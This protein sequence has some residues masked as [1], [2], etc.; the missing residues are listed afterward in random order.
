M[1]FISCY[2]IDVL[3]ILPLLD[4]QLNLVRRRCVL[5][6]KIITE[7]LLSEHNL[8]QHLT[9]LRKI[10]L[11]E[12]GNVVQNFYSYLF[13]EVSSLWFVWLVFVV[14]N[15]CTFSYCWS[16]DKITLQKESRVFCS[17]K[18]CS[19]VGQKTNSSEAL[20][21]FVISKCRVIIP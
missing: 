7:S 20:A 16:K 13:Q 14:V 10:F 3:R 6:N 12:A 11:M 18:N 4:S 17:S 19:T 1:C 2:S 5:A 15:D 21:V 9:V 8:L